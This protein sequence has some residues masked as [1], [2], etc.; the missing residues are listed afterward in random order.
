MASYNRYSNNLIS[1][2]IG[3]ERSVEKAQNDPLLEYKLK[4]LQRFIRPN[5]DPS[6]LKKLTQM[7][8][9]YDSKVSTKRHKRYLSRFGAH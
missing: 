8:N 9:G 3:Q 2:G 4:L 5:M 7:L 6:A 1:H